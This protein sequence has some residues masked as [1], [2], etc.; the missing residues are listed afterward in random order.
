MDTLKPYWEKCKYNLQKS[1]SKVQTEEHDGFSIKQLLKFMGP[2]FLISIAYIDPGNFDTDIQGGAQF[3]YELIW[4]LLLSTLLGMFVQYLCAKL[5]IVTLLDLAQHCKASYKKPIVIILWLMAEVA[6][7]CSDIPEVIGT[8]FALNLL[9]GIPLWLGVLITSADTLLLL[10]LQYFSIR[11]LEIFIGLLLFAVSFCFVIELGY[12]GI[13][14]GEMF[15]GF[16]P[17]VNSPFYDQ[18]SRDEGQT[19]SNYILA[20]VGIMGAVVMPHNL[21]LH[22][23]LV[24]TREVKRTDK[25]IKKANLY[26]AL[27]S[28]IALGISFFINFAIIAVAA[29]VF[30]GIPESSLPDGQP[31]GLNNAPELLENLLGEASKYVFGVALLCSGQSSTITGTYAGQ[32]VMEGFLDIKISMWLRN[33]ITRSVAIVPSLLVAIIAGASGADRLII[34]SQVVLSIQLPF[35]LIPLVKLTNSRPISGDFVNN[36]VIQITGWIISII[37]IIANLLLVVF[38]AIPYFD[39]LH[40][41]YVVAGLIILIGASI[42]Y[43]IFLGYLFYIPI[44]TYREPVEGKEDIDDDTQRSLINDEENF[45]LENY[46]DSFT[47]N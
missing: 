6:V 42:V 15:L 32:F 10:M 20:A 43:F 13:D 25:A 2:G 21:F 45:G 9:I 19:S 3:K 38:T 44:N 37:V 24:Q 27:E 17:F 29:K 1:P 30:Y 39:D 28:V 35:A 22:S 5:G 23:A 11:I 4:V 47:L 26:N 7:I 12:S 16:I 40:H 8:A 46:D 41:W 18:N 31:P 34:L 36:R 14:W 33:L